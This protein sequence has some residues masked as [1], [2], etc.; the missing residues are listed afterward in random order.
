MSVV[1]ISVTSLSNYT[2]Y[3]NIADLQRVRRLTWDVRSQWLDVGL[4]LGIDKDSLDTMVHKGNDDTCYT[5]VLTV[6]IRRGTA[7]LTN[8]KA[9]LEDPTVGRQDIALSLKLTSETSN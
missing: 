5:E 7:T 1:E 3:L 9:A 2:D 4:A 8:M 6:W